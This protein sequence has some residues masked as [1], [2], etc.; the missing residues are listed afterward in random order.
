MKERKTKKKKEGRKERKYRKKEKKDESAFYF[1]FFSFPFPFF[2]FL[3]FSSF[4]EILG[5]TN[6][7][8]DKVEGFRGEV[9]CGEHVAAG[10]AQQPRH[11]GWQGRR[12]HRVTHAAG[13][14]QKPNVDTVTQRA[15]GEGHAGM[16]RGRNVLRPT[17]SHVGFLCFCVFVFSFRLAIEEF[18]LLVSSPVGCFRRPI[19]GRG[20]GGGAFC[21]S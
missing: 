17:G 15:R 21:G 6:F 16:Q 1:F 7:A 19:D 9:P 12:E 20:R 14:A 4:F 10:R 8:E 2:F 13:L 3:F 11:G 18:R 5:R